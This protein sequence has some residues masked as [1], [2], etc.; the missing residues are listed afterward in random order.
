MRAGGRVVMLDDFG[1]GDSLLRHFGMERVA[2]PRRPAEFLRKNPQLALAEPASAHPVVADVSRVV[3][4]HPTGLSHPDLSPVLKIRGN[5]EAGRRRRRRG[6]GRSGASPRR[7]RPLDRDEL[8]A[9]LRGQQGVRARAR[10]V[11]RRSRLVGQARRAP[12]HRLRQLRAEGHLRRRGEHV[13]RLD[14]RAP[15][16]AR[17]ASATT[18]SRRWLAYALACALGLALVVWVG[19]RAGRLHKP[20]DAP[21]RPARYRRSRRVA[22]PAMRR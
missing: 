22:S 12:V 20:V 8:D 6:R 10:P 4:N 1:R 3:T 14:A 16:R 2:S 15:R 5:G 21:V 9:P 11:H 7:R 13:E 18:A 17:G 19:S